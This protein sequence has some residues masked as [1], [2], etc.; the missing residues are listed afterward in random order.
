MSIIGTINRLSTKPPLSSLA[1][2]FQELTDLLAIPLRPLERWS[3]ERRA[4]RLAEIA[5]QLAAAGHHQ[6][7]A[8]IAA[9]SASWS[10]IAARYRRR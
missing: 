7:S 8:E 2:A 3:A 4:R 1:S 10:R 6:R 9:L 5:A